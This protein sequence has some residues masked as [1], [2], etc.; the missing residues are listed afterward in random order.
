MAAKRFRDGV[1]GEDSI[2]AYMEE[3]LDSWMEALNLLSSLEDYYG[4]TIVSMSWG[5]RHAIKMGSVPFAGD[6]YAGDD[7]EYHHFEIE[8][9]GESFVVA[10][11]FRLRQL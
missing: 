6:K 2:M 3:A 11:P 4:G 5:A 10:I 8:H 7:A 1:Y 9:G